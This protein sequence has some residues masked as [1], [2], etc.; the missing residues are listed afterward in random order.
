MHFFYYLVDTLRILGGLRTG[1][2][3]VNGS[4]TSLTD[5][6]RRGEIDDY[7]NGGTIWILSAGNTAPE[8]EFSLIT[9]FGSGIFTFSALTAAIE[10]GDRYSASPGQYP[11]DVLVDCVNMAIKQYRYPRIDQDS[12]AVLST[13]EYDLPS[14]IK[15]GRLKEVYVATTTTSED[16]CWQKVGEWWTVDD[17]TNQ[18]LILPEDLY[19]D[20]PGNK[21]RLDYEEIHDSDYTAGDDLVF[22][23]LEPKYVIFRAAEYMLLQQMY[24]GDEWPYLEERMNYF[25]AKA[26]AYEEEFFEKTRQHR[27]ES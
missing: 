23:W 4:T 15:Y 13:T 7:W 1:L 20:Y 21:L 18:V 16:Y 25:M 26:D 24:D 10:S 12:L 2:A 22:D 27:R 11:Y 14:A 19:P 8:R 3:T 9:D 6:T 17:G 5:T